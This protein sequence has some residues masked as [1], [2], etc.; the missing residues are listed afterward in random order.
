[1]VKIV[2][3]RANARIAC[4]GVDALVAVWPGIKRWICFRRTK[5]KKMKQWIRSEAV[6]LVPP[7]S[8]PWFIGAAAHGL[9]AVFQANHDSPPIAEH[10]LN[11]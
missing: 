6:Q 5:S 2:C 7:S 1:V 9:D 3:T 11:L 8:S 10:F 4:K